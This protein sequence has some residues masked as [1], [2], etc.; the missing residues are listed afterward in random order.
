MQ[1]CIASSIVLA[2]A[3]PPGTSFGA[4]MMHVL[5]TFSSLMILVSG[6]LIFGGAAYLVATKRRPSVLAAYLLLLPVPVLIAIFCE[7]SGMVS[8]LTAIASLPGISV[9]PDHVAANTAASLATVLFAMLVS[10]PTYF[11]LA[12]GLLARTLRSPTDE[13]PPTAIRSKLREPLPSSGGSVPA[14]A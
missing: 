13:V 2:Q 8:A 10:A 9:P 14:T 11:V 1:N 5:G 4:S 6:L 12:F 7:M 3:I